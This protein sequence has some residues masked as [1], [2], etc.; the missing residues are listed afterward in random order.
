MFIENKEDNVI[1]KIKV[2]PNS[3]KNCIKEIMGDLLKVKINASP[4]DN[5]ANNEL[6]CYLAEIFN[7]KKSDIEIIKGLKARDKIVNIKHGKYD[8]ILQRVKEVIL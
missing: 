4:E 6:K 8:E 5:K 1:L 7:I 3:P 2:I